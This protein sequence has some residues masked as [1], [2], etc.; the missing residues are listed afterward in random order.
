MDKL[1]AGDVVHVKAIVR[2]AKDSWVSIEL[3]CTGE[4]PPPTPW[5]AVIPITEVVHVERAPLKVGDSVTWRG[6]P[7]VII[8]FDPER[9]LAWVRDPNSPKIGGSYGVLVVLDELE[10]A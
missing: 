7:G 8:A 4:F 10:C 6:A 5:G 1:K 3:K 2:D 9:P